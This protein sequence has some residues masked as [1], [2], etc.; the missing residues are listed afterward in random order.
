MALTLPRIVNLEERIEEKNKLIISA[1]E[2]QTCRV[3][4]AKAILL[5]DA[6]VQRTIESV[7]RIEEHEIPALLKQV[8]EVSKRIHM[9]AE[10]TRSCG[11]PLKKIHMLLT[12]VQ[13]AQY[14]AE[15]LLDLETKAKEVEASLASD[16]LERLVNLLSAYE[17][18]RKQ[19]TLDGDE[20]SAFPSREM[21]GTSWSSQMTDAR[22][23]AVEKL[24]L[25]VLAAS[26]ANDK[27]SVVS[28]TSLLADL[29]EKSLAA[30]LYCDHV[31]RVTFEPLQKSVQ[32]ELGKMDTPAV[33][34]TYLVLI[35]EVFDAVAGTVEEEET[36][37]NYKFGE[38]S[39]MM[40]LKQLHAEA[41]QLCV[42]II[43]NFVSHRED[44]SSKLQNA[45][46]ASQ[47][48]KATPEKR[49]QPAE[50]GASAENS[51]TVV[52]S[53]VARR[54]D[55]VLEEMSHIASCC[56]I[57]FSFFAKKCLD[58]ESGGSSSE[59]GAAH[60]WESQKNILFTSVQ[61]M[62]AL[63]CPIQLHYFEVVFSQAL[64]LQEELVEKKV[65]SFLRSD[66]KLKNGSSKHN[67]L[68]LKGKNGTHDVFSFHDLTRF[69]TG[70]L[71][72]D[73]Q[74]A[75]SDE[76]LELA[77]Y[78]TT[79]IVTF[80]DDI[81]YVLR[82]AVHRAFHTMSNHVIAAVLASILNL[83]SESFLPELSRQA[84]CRKDCFLSPRTLRWISAAYQSVE[85]ITKLGEEVKHL[86]SEGSYSEKVRQRLSEQ[87]ADFKMSSKEMKA[88]VDSWIVDSSRILFKAIS[89]LPLER[90][91]TLDYVMSEETLFFYELNDPWAQSFIQ[92]CTTI[93]EDVQ[94]ML[95]GEAFN[96]F[97]L[98]FGK[99]LAEA[100]RHSI[101]QKKFNA[102][103][104]LQVDKD[105]RAISY[106]LS[107]FTTNTV[108]LR[109][110]FESLA[111]MVSLLLVDRPQDALEEKHNT[112][113]TS[114]EKKQVLLQRVDFDP[115]EIQALAL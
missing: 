75:A 1:V 80:P 71:R 24:K 46:K 61:E 70:G 76:A 78:E 25:R 85:Y 106:I 51:T 37:L 23:Q 19:L 115:T 114:A 63:Y 77:Y 73:A 57:Y 108:S 2:A 45:L 84:R 100:L 59:A 3:E 34:K 11:A 40:L 49:I 72:S 30:T 99:M 55:Q 54:A 67:M 83:L 9:F 87:A 98:H 91:S 5:M 17:S 79:D 96:I 53:S 43:T 27:E 32:E 97:L 10:E 44:V 58:D 89:A 111:L 102:F 26:V 28:G 7:N 82:M 16:D 31:S 13:E 109:E 15:G 113:L 62:L 8:G 12:R 68:S 104:A 48:A 105:V 39:S 41:T 66:G 65:A 21:K 47:A 4:E 60:V 90:F 74:E 20:N 112:C 81:F 107:S 50:A 93:F 64:A 94:K 95:E 33:A 29:G 18:S 110:S 22:L 35:S 14:V 103:G 38:H 88:K 69:Y 92:E 6:S 101:V 36:F 86:A 42:P 56:Q 52:L